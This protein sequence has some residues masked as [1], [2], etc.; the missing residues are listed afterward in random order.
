[1]Y[2][3]PSSAWRQQKA[4]PPKTNAPPPLVVSS[5]V[6]LGQ[7]EL[8]PVG[9][10]PSFPITDSQ[11]VSSGPAPLSDEY[12][13]TKKN[14]HCHDREPRPR[15]TASM[16]ACPSRFPMLAQDNDC[17]VRPGSHVHAVRTR[18][19]R[20]VAV[21]LHRG[22]RLSPPSDGRDGQLF[23]KQQHSAAQQG[24]EQPLSP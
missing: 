5:L 11:Q 1:M 19:S 22:Q 8:L 20:R 23:G 24:H 9:C 16:P 15:S 4:M 18:A 10:H 17:P 13:V 7:A 12:R 3:A 21:S 6:R 2:H 14:G